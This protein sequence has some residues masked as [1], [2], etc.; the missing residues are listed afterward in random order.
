MSRHSL[1]RTSIGCDR[2][3]A[4]HRKGTQ[5]LQSHVP[6]DYELLRRWNPRETQKSLV[7]VVNG[8]QLCFEVFGVDSERLSLEVQAECSAGNGH[9]EVIPFD[10]PAEHDEDVP[11]LLW[12]RLFGACASVTVRATV[13]HRAESW[14]PREA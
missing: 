12:P 10:V 3:L 5:K 7:Q 1:M 2:E 14:S 8:R 9:S 13:I 4:P 6:V 11:C